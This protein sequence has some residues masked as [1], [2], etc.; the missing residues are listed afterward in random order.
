MGDAPGGHTTS[1]VDVLSMLA[2][3]ERLLR[4]NEASPDALSAHRGLAELLV[5]R[6]PWRASVHAREVLRRCP[7]DDGAWAIL[8]LSQALLGN[9]KFA[10]KSYSEA[11]HRSPNNPWYAHNLGHVLDVILS[12]PEA[13]LPWLEKAHASLPMDRSVK[14]SLAHALGRLGRLDEA[15]KLLPAFEAASSEERALSR[16]LDEKTGDYFVARALK[17]PPPKLVPMPETQRETL[18]AILDAGLRSLPLSPAH[19]VIAK[20]LLCE[21][22][23]LELSSEGETPL[24]AAVVYAVAYVNGM[25]LSLSEIAASFRASQHSVRSRFEVLRGSLGFEPNDPRF[26]ATADRV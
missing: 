1:E 21:P 7:D 10:V 3:Y 18:S 16:W 26:V 24:V 2:R 12:E 23:V 13:A 22:V 5:E 8:A 9:Y 6:E 19:G 20:E 4:E 14:A 25:P 15:R 17:G 11:L